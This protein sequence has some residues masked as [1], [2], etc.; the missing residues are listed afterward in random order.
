MVFLIQ[1]TQNRDTVA[2]QLK[3]DELIYVTKKAH[4]ALLNIEE[5]SDE[6]LDLIRQNYKTIASH[7]RQK[8]HIK[9]LYPQRTKK[10]I[11]QGTSKKVI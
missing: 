4:N 2:L 9:K 3:L 7:S 11:G 1:S 8:I 5:L 10:E 6:E